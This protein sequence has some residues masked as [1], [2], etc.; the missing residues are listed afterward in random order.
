[1]VL[2]QDDIQRIQ[3]FLR[4][5]TNHTSSLSGQVRS[6]TPTNRKGHL[7]L[8]SSADTTR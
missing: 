7:L 5:R 8:L 4:H 2:M 1:M 6:S 3:N